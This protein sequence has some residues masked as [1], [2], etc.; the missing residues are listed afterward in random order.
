MHRYIDFESFYLKISYIFFL[1]NT[2]FHQFLASLGKIS[3][4]FIIF[5]PLYLIFEKLHP[6]L[7]F[8]WLKN[9]INNPIQQGDEVG[10]GEKK[11]ERVSQFECFLE[12]LLQQNI[13]II[14]QK[15]LIFIQI[16]TSARYKLGY[17]SAHMHCVTMNAYWAEFVTELG[18]NNS[19]PKRAKRERSHPYSTYALCNDECV[20]G[21][22][23]NGAMIQ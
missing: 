8:L 21:R 4:T 12:C 23:C 2:F 5:H 15:N 11:R 3:C 16:F 17:A 19:E 10:A 7:Y 22:M 6:R 9:L 14:S 13:P 18:S 1:S 20:Y